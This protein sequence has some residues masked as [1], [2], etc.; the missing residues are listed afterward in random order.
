M[1][2][3]NLRTKILHGWMNVAKIERKQRRED[4]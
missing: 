2:T 3:N 4:K 1:F